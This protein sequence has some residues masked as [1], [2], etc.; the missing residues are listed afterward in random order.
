MV[1]VGG[2]SP[3]SSC[4]RGWMLL[5]ES[6]THKV[7]GGKQCAAETRYEKVHDAG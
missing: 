2:R 6:L 1:S 4:R 3:N 5:W 7:G